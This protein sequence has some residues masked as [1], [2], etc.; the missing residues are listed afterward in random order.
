M[1]KRTKEKTPT[2]I[3][4]LRLTSSQLPLQL[5]NHFL[6]P[7]APCRRRGARTPRL[8]SSLL[9]K[10]GILLLGVY[11]IEDDVESARED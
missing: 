10:L 6:I 4:L 5:L 2:K 3:P 11:K 9:L 8:P 7:L 1:Q